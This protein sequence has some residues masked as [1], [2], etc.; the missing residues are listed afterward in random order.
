MRFIDRK[1]GFTLTE[2]IIVISVLAVLASLAIG[3]GRHVKD[4]GKIKLTKSTI[5]ILVTATEL[6]FSDNN[7]KMPFETRTTID[8]DFEELEFEEQLCDHFVLPY[9]AGMLFPVPGI[10]H[11]L[12]WSGEALYYFLSQS[13]N[14]R[15]IIGSIV[16]TLVTTKDDTGN[17]NVTAIVNDAPLAEM[18]RFVDAWGNTI[19]YRYTAGESFCLISSPGKDKKYG[20][21]DDINNRN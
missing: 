11:G 9:Q 5:E 20:T 6:Y 13:L 7:D 1:N 3:V 10:D 15:R 4:Q 19:R 18:P 8:V 16:A 17:V 2:I 12:D 21:P 14:S